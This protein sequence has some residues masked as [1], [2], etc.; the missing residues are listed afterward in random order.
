MSNTLDTQ[1][2]LASF[3]KGDDSRVK[4]TAPKRSKTNSWKLNVDVLSVD[5]MIVAEAAVSFQQRVQNP[6][7]GD[8]FSGG[9]S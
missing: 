1:T 8:T 9:S 5:E 4:L 3:S 2:E 7:S 6:G